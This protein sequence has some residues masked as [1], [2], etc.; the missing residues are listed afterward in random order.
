M[1]EFD[2]RS[3]LKLFG[4]G[5]AAL[6]IGMGLSKKAGAQTAAPRAGAAEKES[7]AGRYQIFQPGEYL[8]WE[9]EMVEERIAIVRKGP[10]GGRGE[11]G[12]PISEDAIIEANR[13]WDP[14]NP[15]FNDREYARKAGY[16]S[17][18]AF[19][20]TQ[21]A[22]RGGG[23]RLPGIPHSFGDLF[24]YTTDGTDWRIDRHIFAGDT[25]VSE[26]E[27]LFFDDITAPG[28]DVRMF[29]MGSPSKVYDAKSG[30]QIGW[31]KGQNR[32]AYKKIID[33]NP[34]PSVSEHLAEW[35]DY[36]DPPHYTTDEEY[37]VIKELWKNEYIRGSQ[38]LYW[39]DV[40]VGDVP[41]PVCAGP[42]SYMDIALEN[43]GGARGVRL[44]GSMD[45]WDIMY[46]DRFGI[47]LEETALHYGARNMLD[48]NAR[49]ILF[50]GTAANHLIRMV[51][52][53]IGD[54]G[55]VTRKC[56]RIK[57]FARELQ[58]PGY[59]GLDEMEPVPS[60]KGRECTV[61]GG[62]GDTIITRGYV[63]KKYKNEKGEGI[64]DIACWAETFDPGRIIGIVGASAKLP[65][66]KG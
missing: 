8:D 39:E 24:Y 45:K 28:S 40:K 2:R 43:G 55:V 5:T 23:T 13:K 26:Q 53:Y 14:Y 20:G 64:I 60:M 57:A 29:K 12:A 32:E 6:G 25:L 48:P 30:E 33:G 49:M 44:R 4:Q 35:V 17:V 59:A 10:Q 41:T 50:N 31:Q 27:S 62:E 38:K 1:Q 47:Y 51:T 9:K 16:P 34:K 65:L 19:P 3:F 56:H 46:R 63:T 36:L 37:E 21:G 66:K 15:L 11:A 58:V 18:P 42:Y 52:N 61:H 22:G 54:A 7:T